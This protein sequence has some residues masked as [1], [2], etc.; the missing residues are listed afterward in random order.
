MFERALAGER[1]LLSANREA[2]PHEVLIDIARLEGERN[3]AFEGFFS[4]ERLEVKAGQLR[5]PPQDKGA[6]IWIE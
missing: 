1:V 5:L 3:Y 6:E 2:R 4:G